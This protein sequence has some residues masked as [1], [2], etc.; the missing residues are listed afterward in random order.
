MKS[1]FLQNS[2]FIFGIGL[3]II[4]VV[5]G[6]S[7]QAFCSLLIVIYASLYINVIQVQKYIFSVTGFYVALLTTIRYFIIPLMIYFDESYLGYSI[8]N[9]GMNNLYFMKGIL[10]TCWEAIF[11]GGLLKWQYSKWG[12]RENFGDNGISTKLFLSEP[13]AL[14]YVIIILMSVFVF[15]NPIVLDNYSFMFS[16]KADDGS[17]I[18][19]VPTNLSMI[20]S[21]MAVRVLKV[22]LPIPIVC[23]FYRKYIYT[24]SKVAFFIPAAFFVFIYAL[25]MEGASRNSVI[26]PGISLIFILSYVY[27]RYKSSIWTTMVVLISITSILSILWKVFGNITSD[28]ADASSLS[29]WTSYLEVY[30]AGIS[31]MGKAVAAKI[32]YVEG[33]DPTILY[34]DLVQNMPFLSKTA[35]LTNCSNFYYFKEWQRH[36]QIIPASGNGLFAFGYI[37]API[38]PFII[39]KFGHY[40]EIKAAKCNS[41]SC[42][43]VYVFACSTI[44]YNMFNSISSLMMKFSITLFPL[45]VIITINRIINK[46]K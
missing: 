30:F 12:N 43:V 8:L 1:K 7:K 29:Y 28:M 24:G 10:F 9:S 46:V 34:N 15:M 20:V 14:W 6:D 44:C 42:L 21:T 11:F 18:E 4:G 19:D 2:I 13:T 36:D 37:I 38:V 5:S 23:H 41:V 45:L 27:P 16:L 3:L 32:N 26:I 39:M 17:L 31:N 33:I 25:L 35:N 40:F 22:I